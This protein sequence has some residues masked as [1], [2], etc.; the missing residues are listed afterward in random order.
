MTSYYRP[1]WI[2]QQKFNLS[3]CQRQKLKSRCGRGRLSLKA[4][5]EDGSLPLT[6][7]SG[8]QGSLAHDHHWSLPPRPFSYGLSFLSVSLFL[9]LTRILV[10]GF[11]AYLD[12]PG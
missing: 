10:T 4:L 6:A 7:A 1:H 12:N 11:R 2:E 3:Q 8:P 9:S 5:G